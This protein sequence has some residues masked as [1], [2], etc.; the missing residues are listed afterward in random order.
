MGSVRH[1][2]GRLPQRVYW[3]RRSLVL[4]VALL[5]VFGIGKLLGGNGQDPAGSGVEASNTAAQQQPSSSAPTV[6]PVAPSTSPGAKVPKAVLL[7]PSGECK[8]DE[9]SVLPSV[10]RAW[11]A[12]DITI[13][14]GLQGIAEPQLIGARDPHELGQVA[15]V[16]LPSE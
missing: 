5:L 2:R 7:P 8:D 4:V 15:D 16:G 13:R 10:P 14:L 11:G 6:G 1:P 3:V 12:G 9:V